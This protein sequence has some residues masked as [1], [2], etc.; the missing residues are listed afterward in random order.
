[1]RQQGE[2]RGLL[3]VGQPLVGRR[4]QE[5]DPA[6]AHPHLPEGPATTEP[7]QHAQPPG[8][9]GE[10]DL[11]GA[12]RDAV[13]GGGNVLRDRGVDG[14]HPSTTSTTA[15]SRRRA[16]GATSPSTS[17][18]STAIERTPDSTWS[19]LDTRTVTSAPRNRRRTSYPSQSAGI[20]GA[21]RKPSSAGC[22]PRRYCVTAV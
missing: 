12:S 11:P 8:L 4:A 16:A 22:T 15:P 5:V 9:G 21:M 7:G 3:R 1:P 17:T 18:P 20:A 10:H 2:A 13:V 14:A 19:G 6:L